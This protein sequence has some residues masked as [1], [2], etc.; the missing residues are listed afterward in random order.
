MITSIMS[1]LRNPFD[2]GAI[3]PNWCS[4]CKKPGTLRNAHPDGLWE[5]WILPALLLAP[6]W[7]DS[8]GTR[9]YGFSFFEMAGNRLG[10]N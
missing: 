1:F 6:F 5:K 2:V 8:C 4:H 7:C 3:R 9:S 10:E